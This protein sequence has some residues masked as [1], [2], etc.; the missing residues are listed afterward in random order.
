WKAL[1]EKYNGH[2]KEARRA[3]HEKLVNTKMEPGQD[4][5]DLCFVLDECR[6]LLEEMGQTVHDER[7]EDII[8]QAL[9]PEYE[10]V[11]TASYERRDFGLDDIRHMVHTMYV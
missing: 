10:S 5:D 8:L 7:Y 1:T 9:P 2:T 6:D 3:C 4:P 11:R